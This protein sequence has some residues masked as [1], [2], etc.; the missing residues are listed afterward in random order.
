MLQAEFSHEE[1]KHL[2]L[3]EAA[4]HQVGTTC[5]TAEFQQH[6]HTAQHADSRW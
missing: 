2:E 1:V 3:Q 5:V 4:A 6:L